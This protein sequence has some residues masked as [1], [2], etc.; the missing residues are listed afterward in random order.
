MPSAVMFGS[1]PTGVKQGTP[2]QT[3]LFRPLASAE[4]THTGALAPH[5][6]L[7]LDLF[8]MPVVQPYVI[9]DRFSTAGK[10][11]MNYQILPFTW[12]DRS[13]GLR[14]VLKSEMVAAVGNQ[15]KY[16][17]VNVSNSPSIVM[18]QGAPSPSVWTD[19]IRK[20]LDIDKTLAQFAARFDQPD[21]N[22]NVFISPSEICDL[23]MIPTGGPDATGMANW[24][25]N[26]RQTGD[27]LREKIYATVYPKLTTKSNTYTVYFRAQSLKKAP[28]SL[29]GTWTEGKD[30]VTGEYRGSTTIER[31]IS[32]DADIPNYAAASDPS[33]LPTLDT[34]YKWHI[35]SNKQ[36]AP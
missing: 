18:A 30:A 35:I 27:N 8:W 12:I 14:A 24:W 20:T 34:F 22:T 9:S 23:Y 15:Q 19:G 2:W 31:F 1:L 10:I 16:M 17:K 21:H 28:N 5:D 6:N 7:L 29:T 3:L 4:S 25:N 11:N 32:P 33:T 36:F 13:T 26:Y